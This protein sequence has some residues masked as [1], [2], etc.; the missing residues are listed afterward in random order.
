MLTRLLPVF[1]LSA[2]T[3]CGPASTQPVR[4]MALILE[5]DAVYRPQEVELHTLRDPVAL[6]GSVAKT[7]G[8][9]RIVE[10]PN[11]PL[12]VNARTPEDVRRA[13]HKG[14][15]LP[16]RVNYIEKD[17]VLWPADFH[18]WNLVTGYYGLERAQRY[19][20]ANGGPSTDQL[21]AIDFF[22]FPEF[23][24]G[25]GKP[26]RNNALFFS[27]VGG[28][29]LLPFDENL[30]EAPLAVNAGVLAHEWSHHIFNHKVHDGALLPEAIRRWAGADHPA[31][32]VLFSVEEGLADFHA[33]MASC[34]EGGG[35][36]PTFLENSF[37]DTFSG[38]RDIS[39]TD[40]CM[41]A[42]LRDSFVTQSL[43]E[44]RAQG[45]DYATG[46][47]IASA[48]FQAGEASGLQDELQQAVVASYASAGNGSPG[49]REL[50]SQNLGSPD[51][52][53]LGVLLNAIVARASSPP[54]KDALCSEFLDHL[55]LPRSDLAACPPSSVGGAQCPTLA[56]EGGG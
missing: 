21:G 15:G 11:D 50:I 27:P 53:R 25:G 44:F 29:L 2:L 23:V 42:G 13:L 40:H 47:I 36:D 22:Y 51:N 24:L 17:G 54:L 52:I 18:S 32:K 14:A 8:G 33:V 6:E 20:E 38:P 16:P 55:K 9:A 43:G 10:D 49:L 30:Q 7:I 26:L 48:L 28:M 5:A 12:L 4:A 1:V 45:F 31:A 46:T 56:G 34:S 35:C 41:S 19:F 37:A 3:A 39:R